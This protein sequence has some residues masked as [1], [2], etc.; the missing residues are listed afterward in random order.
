MEVGQ[1]YEAIAYAE[2]LN[3]A[4][5][6]KGESD[7]IKAIFDEIDGTI[8]KIRDVWQSEAAEKYMA[9]YNQLKA[10]LPSF[11][12]AVNEYSQFLTRTVNAYK[13]AD[14]TI[15]NAADSGFSG[16]YGKF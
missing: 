10:K 6:L 14:L 11:Y 13:D 16:K 1:N 2:V 15:G 4:Q 12:M 5:T 3:D 7:K 8:N 9:R